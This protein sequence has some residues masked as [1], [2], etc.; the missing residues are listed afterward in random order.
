[1]NATFIMSLILNFKL[2]S[3]SQNPMEKIS[4]QRKRTETGRFL[5]IT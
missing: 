4:E 5:C 1:M 2:K 3:L